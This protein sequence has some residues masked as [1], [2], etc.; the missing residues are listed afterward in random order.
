MTPARSRDFLDQA[1]E[2]QYWRHAPLVKFSETPCEAGK[3]YQGL[4]VHTRS[5]LEELGYDNAAITLLETNKVVGLDHY[6]D[7]PGAA[8]G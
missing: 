6:E 7:S 2:G 3:P 4:G 5:V 1:P 8:L